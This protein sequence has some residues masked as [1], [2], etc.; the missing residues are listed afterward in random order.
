MA[1]PGGLAL[2]FLSC[3]LVWSQESPLSPSRKMLTRPRTPGVGRGPPS[4][5]YSE[6][7]T[8]CSNRCTWHHGWPAVNPPL[9]VVWGAQAEALG[10]NVRRQ[11]SLCLLVASGLYCKPSPRQSN[12]C[13]ASLTNPSTWRRTTHRNTS[14]VGQHAPADRWPHSS[15]SCGRRRSQAGKDPEAGPG[16]IC[17][18]AG[19][20]C[21]CPCP[22]PA[23][24]PTVAATGDGPVQVGNRFSSQLLALR[25]QLAQKRGIGRPPPHSLRGGGRHQHL[26]H[27]PGR[28]AHDFYPGCPSIRRASASRARQ[29]RLL[30]AIPG[31]EA[32]LRSC[33]IAGAAS[34]PHPLPP[35]FADGAGAS[36]GGGEGPAPSPLLPLRGSRRP[37]RGRSRGRSRGWPVKCPETPSR[38]APA[39][40]GARSPS[41]R[42][43]RREL[44]IARRGGRPPS[45][46]DPAGLPPTPIPPASLTP[47]SPPASLPPRS[48]PSHPDPA[49]H[50]PIP[51][52]S[53]TPRSRPSH[54]D[55]APHTPI[56]PAS[57]TPRSRPSHPDPA[58]HTP[59]PPASLTLGSRRPPSHPGPSRPPLALGTLGPGPSTR[60]LSSPRLSLGNPVRRWV[61]ECGCRGT[62]GAHTPRA[63]RT[64]QSRLKRTRA[65][66]CGLQALPLDAAMI[67]GVMRHRGTEINKFVG[68]SAAS[69]VCVLLTGPA[70]VFLS[71]TFSFLLRLCFLFGVFSHNVCIVIFIL[72]IFLVT[73]ILFLHGFDH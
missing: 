39:L 7:I 24:P 52:A 19:T 38:A 73:M 31:A 30:V 61:F 9:Q 29:K 51:P 36:E 47:R 68:V 67:E 6:E 69:P 22:T 11:G 63:R 55:P 49:P 5:S 50:T 33:G 45:H 57:L 62:G 65:L 40:T 2:C 17:V 27:A 56:P 48:R 28:C 59:A 44:S 58:P 20:H 42:S 12:G 14:G 18:P 16:R 23:R 25:R 21:R 53:L 37:S 32:R 4:S 72:H 46:P 54:P 43:R 66:K 10:T 41:M 64:P 60:G 15:F 35:G 71:V 13:C 8:S 1:T 26:S 34:G 3:H 70:V